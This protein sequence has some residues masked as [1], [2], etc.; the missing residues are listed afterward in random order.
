MLNVDVST[1]SPDKQRTVRLCEQYRQAWRNTLAQYRRWRRVC[2]PSHP[3]YNR[4]RT[5]YRESLW[6]LAARI[7]EFEFIVERP[8]PTDVPPNTWFS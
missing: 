6:A 5:S 3:L 4:V 8:E 2:P 1:L 7:H